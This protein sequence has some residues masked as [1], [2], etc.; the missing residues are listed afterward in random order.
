ML[1]NEL[2]DVY[3]PKVDPIDPFQ[4]DIYGRSV[5]MR[6]LQDGNDETF[7]RVAMEMLATVKSFFA[8]T[9]KQGRV[10]PYCSPPPPDVAGIRAKVAKGYSSAFR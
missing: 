7:Q 1:L 5:E 10:T 8:Q 6:I 2:T 3:D 4:R 9:A